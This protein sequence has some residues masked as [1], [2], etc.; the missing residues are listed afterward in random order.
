MTDAR[1]FNP[2]IVYMHQ[3]TLPADTKLFERMCLWYELELVTGGSM[4][5]G[6]VTQEQF[7]P[8]LPGT[9]FLR[10]PGDLV[11]G[12]APFSYISILFDVVYDPVLEPY[13]GIREASLMSDIDL[14]FLN[15][16]FA[17]A[18]RSFPFIERIP[19]VMRFAE[20]DQLL[21]PMRDIIEQEQAE[22]GNFQFYAK[23]LLMGLLARLSRECAAD[24]RLFSE[25]PPA[26]RQAQ[27]FIE[28]NY[29]QALT[30]ETMAAH[31]SLNR[32]YFCRL[33]RQHAGKTPMKYLQDV[34]I[35][36]AKLLLVSEELSV[37]EVA[38]RCGFR[39]LSYFYSV[40]KKHTGQSPRQFKTRRPPGYRQGGVT[41][42]D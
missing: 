16:Y 20:Y 31:V 17:N 10:R 13:Y 1:Y 24:G 40:F 34:R 30:L 8:A 42:N 28:A 33:F 41:G 19:R 26:I 35:Y 3:G 38:G 22:D 37:E 9:L 12:V 32:E 15:K 6:V 4:D 18:N 21:A 27:E 5:A 11:R 36:H 14:A 23:T 25:L 7:V 29:A 39:D 2:Y